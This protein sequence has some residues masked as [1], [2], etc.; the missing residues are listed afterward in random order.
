MK[1]I[2]LALALL[3]TVNATADEG[4]VCGEKF[5][6][7][8]ASASYQGVRQAVVH[9]LEVKAGVADKDLLAKIGKNLINGTH[10]DAYE[11]G[12]ILNL[13]TSATPI[14]PELKGASA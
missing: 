9:Y 5:L 14:F 3:L 10:F 4:T 6:T 13:E 7:T 8:P 11:G 1:G 12:V 2:W